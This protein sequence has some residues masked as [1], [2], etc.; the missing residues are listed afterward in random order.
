MESKIHDPETPI[1]GPW[2]QGTV[3]ALNAYQHGGG[4]HGYTCANHSN[5]LLKATPHGWICRLCDYTQNWASASSVEVG[6]R[7]IAN[8]WR[9]APWRGRG[10]E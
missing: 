8:Q 4:F 7:V 9:S 10:E 2:D 6:K 5:H 3:D 1:V